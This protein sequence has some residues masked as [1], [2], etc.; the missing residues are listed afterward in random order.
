MLQR[1]MYIGCWAWLELEENI[2]L[3]QLFN[4]V[5]IVVGVVPNFEKGIR[6]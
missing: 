4:K 2:T 1:R 5:I 6:L 3:D